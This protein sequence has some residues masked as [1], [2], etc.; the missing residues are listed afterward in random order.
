MMQSIDLDLFYHTYK[1][2]PL[3]LSKKYRFQAHEGFDASQGNNLV[4]ILLSP[5]Y[6]NIQ[7]DYDSF[8]PHLSY[9]CRI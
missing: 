7:S 2:L 4:F 6:L 3:E 1:Q 5:R 9:H 8:P